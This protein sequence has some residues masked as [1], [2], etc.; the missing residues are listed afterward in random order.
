M[1]GLKEGKEY[2]FS[3]EKELSLPDNSV[4]FVLSGPDS[5]KYLLPTAN[6]SHYGITP[7]SDVICRIDRINCKG[8]IF[9]EPRN[10]WYRESRSYPF[11]VDRIE[12]R[13]DNS[14]R[15]C[16]VIVV[17]DVNGNRT[18]VVYNSSNRMPEKGAEINL[19]VERISK[20]KVFLVQSSRK[21]KDTALDGGKLYDFK[22]LRIEKGL[23]DEDYFIIKDPFD[24][25]H[26]I[27]RRYYEYYGF[28]PGTTF[29]GEIVRYKRNGE[30]IIEPENPYYK[31]GEILDLEMTGHKV[32]TINQSFTIDLRD[33]F[34]FTHC[35]D[36]YEVPDSR[37]V[38]CKVIMIRKGKPLLKLM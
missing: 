4:H 14:G 15:R 30:K 26:T 32:N 19:M 25:L 12:K 27:P 5:K 9:L 11:V 36:T 33:E 38:R 28:S 16:D 37:S 3:V 21:I 22:I 34:G 10:P 24:N 13:T 7:G 2:R 17:L 31:T 8:E 18:N 20:G 23:D 29:K 35:L 6:Y 1:A